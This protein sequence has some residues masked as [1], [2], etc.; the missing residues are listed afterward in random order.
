MI[1][2][3]LNSVFLAGWTCAGVA[4]LPGVASGNE[5]PFRM[6]SIDVRGAATAA[7]GLDTFTPDFDDG[8]IRTT[9][10]RFTP[11][12]ETI[13]LQWDFRASFGQIDRAGN[14]DYQAEAP[15]RNA[16][17]RLAWLV[18]PV[19]S[20]LVTDGGESERIPTGEV[21]GML[22]IPIGADLSDLGDGI[23]RLPDGRVLRD[24]SE[25]QLVIPAGSVW[26]TVTDRI[27]PISP[28]L[29]DPE[30]GALVPDAGFLYVCVVSTDAAGE[31]LPR[32]ATTDAAWAAYT[33][34]FCVR[35]VIHDFADRVQDFI[36][37]VEVEAV[38][39]TDGPIN[40]GLR[41]AIFGHDFRD[42]R[43]SLRRVLG[44]SRTFQTEVVA[45]V[46][47]QIVVNGSFESPTRRTGTWTLLNEGDM[48]IDGWVVGPGSV[49]HINGYWSG[50]DG[51]HSV[52]LD[53]SAVGQIYQDLTGLVFGRTYRVAF[54]LSGNPDCGPAVKTVAVSA[55]GQSATFSFDTSGLS[56][57]AIPWVTHYFEFTA[58]AETERLTFASQTGGQYCGPALD[59]VRVQ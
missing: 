53:G 47:D 55:A 40:L 51:T 25:D 14:P 15:V 35:Q 18:N 7:S 48:S 21:A 59:N 39:E 54:D 50:S 9:I 3:L 1:R 34:N 10:R 45:T 49:D 2:T 19:D 42:D 37:D 28:D 41:A 12:G 56:R 38:A 22:E 57:P 33:D 30:T 58:T 31:I 43:A 23:V 16:L 8:G 17:W 29:Y 27:E 36:V 26:N 6:L 46:P 13:R 24:V 4:L 11:I 44:E 52:D 32:V 20:G 5:A